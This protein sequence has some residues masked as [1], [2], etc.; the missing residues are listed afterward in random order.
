MDIITFVQHDIYIVSSAKNFYISSHKHYNKL[1]LKEIYY[2]IKTLLTHL[3]CAVSQI[4][5]NYC[6]LN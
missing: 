1:F 5:T 6:F 3:Q 2:F 4:H